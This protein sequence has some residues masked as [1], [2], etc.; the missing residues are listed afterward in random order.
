M[1]VSGSIG[2]PLWTCAGESIVGL[3]GDGAISA[4]SHA[5][6]ACDVALCCHFQSR[7]PNHPRRVCKVIYE[8]LSSTRV[9]VPGGYSSSS[10]VSSSSNIHIGL[11]RREGDVSSVGFQ[12]APK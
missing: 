11:V 10:R 1:R 2:G 5:T 8:M 4:K 7:F 6:P 9:Y 12:V 3:G